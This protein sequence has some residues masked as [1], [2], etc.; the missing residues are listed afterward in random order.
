[1]K[2]VMLTLVAIF[3]TITLS[4]QTYEMVEIHGDIINQQYLSQY[5]QVDGNGGK[6]DGKFS[7]WGYQRYDE[8]WIIAYEVEYFRGDSSQMSEFLTNLEEF[9][10]KYGNTRNMVTFIHG[11]KVKVGTPQVSNIILIFDKEEK[12]CATFTPRQ[13]G[14]LSEKFRVYCKRK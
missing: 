4:G 11:V 14:K 9:T 7:L 2:R 13:I 3:A 6:L 5:K 8:N 12:V 1:M 10:E